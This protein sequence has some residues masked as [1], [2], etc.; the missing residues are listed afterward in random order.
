MGRKHFVKI[1]QT[2]VRV[3]FKETYL[4]IYLIFTKKNIVLSLFK[5]DTNFTM[6]ILTIFTWSLKTGHSIA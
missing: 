5:I 6:Y 3:V 1:V 2:L 4:G